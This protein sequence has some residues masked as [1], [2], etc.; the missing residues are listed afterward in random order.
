[1]EA[2]PQLSGQACELSTK[3]FAGWRSVLWWR[4]MKTMLHL[5]WN[6]WNDDLIWLSHTFTME[7]IRLGYFKDM[8]AKAAERRWRQDRGLWR[9]GVVARDRHNMHPGRFGDH[10][11]TERKVDLV[12]TGAVEMSTLTVELP[13]WK[14]SFPREVQLW[15]CPKMSDVGY[16]KIC[17]YI[18]IYTYIL[19][20]FRCIDIYIYTYI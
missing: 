12:M 2:F 15:V 1:M 13:S 7:H 8:R 9:F 3:Q 16:P 17:I 18:Y 6:D 10:D 19:F 5:T 20:I 14:C 4:H 11:R